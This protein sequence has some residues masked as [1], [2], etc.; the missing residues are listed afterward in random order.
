MELEELDIAQRRAH[1]VREGPAVARRHDRIRGDGVEL[2]HAARRQDDRRRRQCGERA[3]AR[4]RDHALHAPR[5][6]EQ[7]CDLRVLSDLDERM[8]GHDPR[9][10]AHQHR[11][12]PV[13]AR[14]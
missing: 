8:V 2:T 10:A 13:A 11:P 9:E 14:V 7:L 4:E 5:G 1:P 12:G 6:E 3:V